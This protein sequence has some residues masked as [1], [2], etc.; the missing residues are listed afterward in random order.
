MNKDEHMKRA[1]KF[2]KE[3]CAY[4]HAEVR[5]GVTELGVAGDVKAIVYACYRTLQRCNEISGL[6]L[7]FMLETMEDMYNEEE[8]GNNAGNR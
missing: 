1:E 2:N 3:N 6:P 8:A 7:S 4:V 5:N